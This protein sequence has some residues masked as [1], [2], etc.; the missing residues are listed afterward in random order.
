[1]VA[2]DVFQSNA[3]SMM[4]MTAA[5]ET[6]PHEPRM[7][8]ALGLFKQEPIRTIVAWIDR[9]NGKLSIIHTAN[10]GTVHDV[11]STI[12]RTALPFKVPHV[13]YFQTIIAD[14]IQGIRAFGSE[15]ELQAMAEHVNDQLIGMKKDHEVTHEYHRIGALKGEILDADGVTVIYNLFTAF[16]ISQTVVNWYSTD[17]SFAPH[18]T[19]VI[20]LMGNK[21]GNQTT[22]KIIALCGDAYFDAIV[23]HETMVLAYDRWRDGEFRRVSHLGP[24][25]LTAAANGFEYQ[26]VL[27]INYRGQIG[28]IKFIADN[29][30]Y[31]IPLGIEDLFQ[32]VIAPADFME[33][34]NTKGK[35]FYARQE[36]IA[37]NKGVQ[38]HTQSNV[39][40]MCTR[41]DVI[42]K[43]VWAATNPS[44]SSA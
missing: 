4:S 24:Q 6:A 13:P 42:I 37:F 7:L 2:M 14:D 43:S 39:L 23:G 19:A 5:I 12:P 11:R 10:R 18:V 40:A 38:L 28:D 20:R 41:P 22:T 29:E 35:K 26:N 8:G 36:P 31:Y 25:W 3:F 17:A 30:A 9:K 27:F 32:E 16:G 21:L 15:T 1:M 33:T 34:V 44:S